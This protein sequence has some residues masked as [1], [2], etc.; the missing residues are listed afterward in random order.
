M[1]KL[2]YYSKKTIKYVFAIFV[3]FVIVSLPLLS[4]ARKQSEDSGIDIIDQVDV[5]PTL[6]PKI[7]QKNY[8]NTDGEGEG[9]DLVLTFDEAKWNGWEPIDYVFTLTR[10]PMPSGWVVDEQ[11]ILDYGPTYWAPKFNSIEEVEESL[12]YE[13]IGEQYRP[14]ATFA[15]E[16]EKQEYVKQQIL[17]NNNQYGVFANEYADTENPTPLLRM[18]LNDFTWTLEYAVKFRMDRGEGEY[19]DYTVST[20]HEGL[21]V[22]DLKII[23]E[24]SELFSNKENDAEVI[25]TPEITFEANGNDEITTGQQAITKEGVKRYN[26][27]SSFIYNGNPLIELSNGK[28]YGIN[29]SASTFSIYTNQLAPRLQITSEK[30]YYLDI[31]KTLPTVT[32]NMWLSDDNKKTVSSGD[33]QIFE[34]EKQQLNNQYQLENSVVIMDPAKIPSDAYDE[35]NDL[36]KTNIKFYAEIDYEYK[37]EAEILALHPGAD[38]PNLPTSLVGHD[39][40]GALDNLMQVQKDDLKI[41]Q[42]MARFDKSDFPEFVVYPNWNDAGKFNVVFATKDQYIFDSEYY[43]SYQMNVQFEHNLFNDRTGQLTEDGIWLPKFSSTD[44]YGERIYYGQ[45][46]P[47]ATVFESESYYYANTT[48]IENKYTYTANLDN[49]AIWY[50]P[51]KKDGTLAHKERF[52]YYDQFMFSSFEELEYDK[53]VDGITIITS[54]WFHESSNH[55]PPEYKEILT[56]IIV[57]IIIL[58]ILPFVIFIILFIRNR[59]TDK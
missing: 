45:V 36:V 52:V 40:I 30:L 6:V 20:D 43:Y 55:I 4:Y 50:D 41:F 1:R 57:L 2:K 9:A 16:E 48:M 19:S 38:L 37:T 13:L 17:V 12:A 29:G 28:G 32:L 18:H 54:Q 44:E 58:I 5:A 21:P 51:S 3:V 25:F 15:T 53:D 22:L 42:D 46:F 31:F 39:S 27:I 10:N 47:N 59:V 7:T 24:E 33:I 14:I 35:N 34:N 23:K 8:G 11:D 26:V 49:S 56:T